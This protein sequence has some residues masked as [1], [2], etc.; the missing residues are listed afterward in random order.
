MAVL[1]GPPPGLKMGSLLEP[2][3][4]LSAEPRGFAG[5]LLWAVE[6]RLRVSFWAA[7]LKRASRSRSNSDVTSASRS[8]KIKTCIAFTHM[9]MSTGGMPSQST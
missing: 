5:T 6:A 8:V 4:G 7:R 2:A 1:D 3:I 9:S